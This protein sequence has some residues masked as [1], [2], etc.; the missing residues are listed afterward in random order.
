MDIKY[1]TKN[2]PDDPDKRTIYP[3]G[4]FKISGAVDLIGDT[5]GLSPDAGGD[6]ASD[7]SFQQ[8]FAGCD[9]RYA[10]DF[11]VDVQI[12]AW[13][14]KEMF[15]SCE[16]LITTPKVIN[17]STDGGGNKFD[18][19]FENCDNLETVTELHFLNTIGGYDTRDYMFANCKNLNR[20]NFKSD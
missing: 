14:C 3:I 8:L 4:K 17:I 6:D 15:S 1:D 5:V 9:I 7:G 11:T 19:M 18:S 20:I 2:D 16:N 12:A 10:H 13:F